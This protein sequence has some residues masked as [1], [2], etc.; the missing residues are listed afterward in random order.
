MHWINIFRWAMA[1]HMHHIY[2]KPQNLMLEQP[3]T[4]HL[5]VMR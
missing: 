4:C 1:Q 2:L 5:L 3:N